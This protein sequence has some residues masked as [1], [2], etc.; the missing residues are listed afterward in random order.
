[1]MIGCL[2]IHGFTGAPNEVNPLAD[3]LKK[4]TDWM[5]RVPTL[6]G[7]GDTLQL[8]GINYKQWLQHAEEELKWLLEKCEIV[9]IIGFS[10]GGLIASYLATLYPVN[11]LVLLS[12]AAYYI[13][14][15]QLAKDI[16]DIVKDTVKGDLGT[17]ELFLRYKKKIT[18]TPIGAT[19]Q[20]RKLVSKVRKIL[21]EVK[22]P[23]FIAQGENDGIVPMKSAQ[24][25]Y[26]SIGASIKEVLYIPNSKHHIC[27]CDQNEQLFKEIL[28]FLKSE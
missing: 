14:V 15:K 8:K 10:M 13:N 6:P 25:L 26:D 1:M 5:I 4:E 16:K 7:H 12:A 2:C 3:Y 23:T 11:K 27:H 28:F 18:A 20:F 17:N 21:P 9:Y 24:Y 22:I 19:V